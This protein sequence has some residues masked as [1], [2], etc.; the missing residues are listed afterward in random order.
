MKRAIIFTDNLASQTLRLEGRTSI[1]EDEFCDTTL[2]LR[3]S[4]ELKEAVLQKAKKENISLAHLTRS[5]YKDF[6]AS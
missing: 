6:L 5:F 2:N 1:F 4:K 3:I